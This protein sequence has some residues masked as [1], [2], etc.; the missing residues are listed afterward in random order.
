MKLLNTTQ[1]SKILGV[2]KSRVRQFIAAGRLPARK[3]GRDWLVKEEDLE[4]VRHRKIGRPRKRS[5]N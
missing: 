3:I 4:L 2:N 1:V 5:A